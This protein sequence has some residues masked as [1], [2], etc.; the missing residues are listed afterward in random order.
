MTATDRTLLVVAAIGALTC[1]VGLWLD[2]RTLLATYLAMSVS[3]V[4]VPVGALGVL[5]V[6]YLVRGGWTRDLHDILGAAART[7]PIAGLLFIPVLLGQRWLYPWAAPAFEGSAFQAIY[8][9]PWFFALRAVVYFCIW[10]A[11]AEWA[12]R[13][14][15]DEAAM[16]RAASAGL[17]IYT[18]TVSLAAID[19]IE[20]IEPHFHSSIYGLIFL[21]FV[22]LSGLSF[23][24]VVLLATRVRPQMRLGAY[25]GLLLSTLLLWAY[26][27]A[28]QYII[29]WAGNVP[30]EV[31]WYLVRLRGGWAFLLWG[32]FVLQFI[33]PFGLLLS[34]R[35]RGQRRQLGLLAG[36]TL[37]L[38]PWEAVVL[39]LPPTQGSPALLIYDLCAALAFIGALWLLAWVAL[40]RNGGNV[41]QLFR[42][43]SRHELAE[44]N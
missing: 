39:C 40:F 15:G 6:S 31:K 18:L 34:A 37:L 25:G 2:A 28:M 38:R 43:R 21:T 23:G 24:I 1:A 32:L 33:V 16:K 41:A 19:W 11:L 42:W 9:T 36:M 44:H 35:W 10:S 12:V 5:M 27:H 7:T 20:S 30:D 22:L 4:S 3:I 13:A 26:N 17:I 29:I 8:L 14:Y